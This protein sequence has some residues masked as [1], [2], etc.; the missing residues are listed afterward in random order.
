M[1]LLTHKRNVFSQN[2][3]D[4]IIEYLFQQLGEGTRTCCEFGAWDGIHLSNCRQLMLQGW[5][6]VFIEG[7][8]GKFKTLQK[9]FSGNPNVICENRF[10]GEGKDSLDAILGEHGI[11]ELDFLSIDIDGKDYEVLCG[12]SLRPRVI[13]IELNAGHRPDATE[14]LDPA[15]AADNVGQPMF[16]FLR[17]AREMGYV[18]VCYTGNLFFVRNDEAA[19]L[20]FTDIDGTEAYRDYLFALTPAEKEHMFLVNLGL[21]YPYHR[22]DN[23]LLSGDAL[24]IGKLRRALLVGKRVLPKL[25]RT[26]IGSG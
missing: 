18:F 10:V 7:D 23:P 4:G 21:V 6:T 11:K 13:C 22:Y 5:K 15:V 1:G 16:A 8:S 12:L 24:S 17:R 9:N 14:L 20:G 2:G 25:K 26:L 19:R 3:E